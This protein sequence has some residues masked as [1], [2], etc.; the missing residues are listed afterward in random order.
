MQNKNVY[1]NF[2]R[3][4]IIRGNKKPHDLQACELAARQY[5][6]VNVNKWVNPDE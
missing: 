5:A 2:E 3:I 6:T 1:Y 4:N